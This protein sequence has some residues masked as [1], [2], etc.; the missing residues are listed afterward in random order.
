MRKITFLAIACCFS[1]LAS[2]QISK[3]STFLGGSL[4]FN[5]ASSK[6]DNQF[7]SESKLSGWSIRPQFGKAIRENRIFGV[8]LDFGRS[9]SENTNGGQ[10]Q[11]EDF[12]G[13]GGGVFYRRYFPFSSRFLLFGEGSLGLN[14]GSGEREQN[15]VLRS[16]IERTSVGAGVT[17]GLSFAAG[18][19]VYLEASLNSLFNINYQSE[20]QKDLA[21]NGSVVNTRTNKQFGLGFN[22]NGFSALSVGLRWILPAR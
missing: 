1:I 13:Y 2:A 10:I 11:K 17:P 5:S 19:R 20:E 21:T 4:G 3:G 9:S 18:K 15:N 16:E 7:P 6:N 22:A 12:S 14:I 8:F